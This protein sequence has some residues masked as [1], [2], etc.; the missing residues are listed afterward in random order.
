MIL[1]DQR[2]LQQ[3]LVNLLS[4][5]VKFTPKG[6][7]VGLDVRADSGQE[8]IH[9]SVWDTGIGIAKEDMRRLFQPFVQL[10]SSLSRA[11]AGTGLGLS[12]VHR[13]AALHG[14]SIALESEVGSGSR[15]TISIPWIQASGKGYGDCPEGKREG[16]PALPSEQMLAVLL[17]ESHEETIRAT[18]ACLQAWGHRV[19]V[20]RNGT[21]AIQQAK[22]ERPDVIMINLEL[23]GMPG[24][25]VLRR[26]RSIQMK[27]R[28]PQTADVPMI[29]TT[30]LAIPGNRERC[31]AYGATEYLRKPVAMKRLV[32]LI[33]AHISRAHSHALRGDR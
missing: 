18:T 10:D 31:I 2:R 1:G 16:A 12:L 17:V 27:S 20:T 29:A 32:P 13:L 8:A 21:E 24:L 15:F 6:G 25:Q 3:M 23:P 28:D 14:G 5:A 9:F 4:N 11:Y 26:L 33:E 7:T 22:E 19:I 30:T